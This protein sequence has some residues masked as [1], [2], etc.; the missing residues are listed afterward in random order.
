MEQYYRSPFISIENKNSAET[1]KSPVH[2]VIKKGKKEM[3]I[4]QDIDEEM[5]FLSM[6][7]FIRELAD[8]HVSGVYKLSQERINQAFQI[9][10]DAIKI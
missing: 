7:G 3:L 6:L 4:K 2:E 5:L 8:E 9:S 10:W 1:M